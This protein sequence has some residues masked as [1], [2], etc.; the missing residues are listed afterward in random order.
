MTLFAKSLTMPKKSMRAFL[1][2][3]P[4]LV[5]PLPS[6][7]VLKIQVYEEYHQKLLNTVSNINAQLQHLEMLEEKWR[8]LI[9]NATDENKRLKEEQAY[10]AMLDDPDGLL[11]LTTTARET[12]LRR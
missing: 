3:E 4:K 2:E 1:A 6:D 9:D 8:H 10:E 11:Q 12:S 5:Q 7:N